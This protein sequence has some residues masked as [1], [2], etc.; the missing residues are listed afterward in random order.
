MYDTDKM[1]GEKE[2]Q[3]V[4]WD[5]LNF[6]L[7]DAFTE[8]ALK[9]IAEDY[10]RLGIIEDKDMTADKV[11][12]LAW[13]PVCPDD[14][15]EGLTVGDPVEPDNGGVSVKQKENPVVSEKFGLSK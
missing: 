10:I 7:S 5:S 11:M 1:T 13:T 8:R 12:E 6:G 9:E 15:I 4:F 2:N 3:M 14:E